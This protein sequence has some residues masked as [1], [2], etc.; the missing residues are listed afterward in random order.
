MEKKKSKLLTWV[1]ISVAV[2]S[3]VFG[4]VFCVLKYIDKRKYEEKWADYDDC[5]V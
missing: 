5:G 1:T 3:A 4:V 2:F